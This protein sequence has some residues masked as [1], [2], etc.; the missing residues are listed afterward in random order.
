[1]DLNP[2]ENNEPKESKLHALIK[3]RNWMVVKSASS[4]TQMEAIRIKE[5]HQQSAAKRDATP[6]KREELATS[7]KEE[8]KVNRQAA[9]F[10]GTLFDAF[11]YKTSTSEIEK[12]L[13]R[14]I[15]EKRSQKDLPSFAARAEQ[16]Q[17]E[18]D[19]A[20][21]KIRKGRGGEYFDASTDQRYK[22]ERSQDASEKYKGS[23]ISK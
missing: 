19:D 6:S 11:L 10:I 1:M 8:G 12:L 18:I 23:I 14:D 16:M 4:E 7:P 13:I 21:D 17:K 20:L 3:T 15:S 2:N 9:V 5:W 22:R